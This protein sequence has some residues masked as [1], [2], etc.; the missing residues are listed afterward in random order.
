VR[1][2]LPA[3]VAVAP[4]VPSV[5]LGDE[6]A[7]P[8][9]AVPLPQSLREMPAGGSDAGDPQ[10]IPRSAVPSALSGVLSILPPIDLS[11]LERGLRQFVAQLESTGQAL[12]R[13]VERAELWPW[14]VAAAAALAACEIARREVRSSEFKGP[15]ID[16]SDF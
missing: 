8:P 7:V 3:L 14:I 1:L 10:P 9:N 2:A 12:L 6:I 5:S 16:F 15:S 11:N 13:P 4:T